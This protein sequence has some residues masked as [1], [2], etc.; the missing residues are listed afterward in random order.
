MPSVL[1]W[2]TNASFTEQQVHLEYPAKGLLTDTTVKARAVRDLKATHHPTWPLL[3]SR[4]GLEGK[5]STS[6]GKTQ[7]SAVPHRWQHQRRTE[8]AGGTFEQPTQEAAVILTVNSAA[9]DQT[10]SSTNL[11]AS[12]LRFAEQSTPRFRR[13]YGT[14]TGKAVYLRP[15]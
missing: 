7:V 15:S 10:A 13:R 5:S 3:Q 8:L 12:F 4:S 6:F 2:A 1:L 14:L 9:P 11:L